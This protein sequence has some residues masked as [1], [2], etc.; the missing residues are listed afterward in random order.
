MALGEVGL[1]LAMPDGAT[2]A[3]TVS[4]RHQ[5][6][7]FDRSSAI[8]FVV[9]AYECVLKYGKIVVLDAAALLIRVL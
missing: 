1:L 7:L 8:S 6:S 2:V 4:L 3:P 5:Q 9:S